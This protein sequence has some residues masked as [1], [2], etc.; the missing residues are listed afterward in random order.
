MTWPSS[1]R[2]LHTKCLFVL[3]LLTTGCARP[4]YYGWEASSNGAT[5]GGDIA[6]LYFD[7]NG[8]LYPAA[9]AF[10]AVD[11]KRL[12]K[13]GADLQDYYQLP[14]ARK[15]Q[16]A[17]RLEYER[18]QAHYGVPLTPSNPADTSVNYPAWRRLQEAMLTQFLAR[19]NQHLR[20]SRPEALVVL[21]HGFNNEVGATRWYPALQR[22]I[23]T[24]QFK[25]RRVQFLEV[26]WDGRTA[27][28]AGLLR[29]WKQAQAT[30]YP[31]GLGLRRVLASVD[32]A[33][34][35]Y[36]FGHSTGA[37][38]LS[39]A[40]WNSTS[41]LGNATGPRL[42]NQTYRA[43]VKQPEYATPHAAQVRVAFVAPAMPSL[44]FMDF[45]NRTDATGKLFTQTTPDG[46]QRF[47]VGQN[48]HDFATGKGPLSATAFGS[49]TLGV[50]KAE[51]CGD[52][53]TPPGIGVVPLLRQAGSHADT[54]LFNFTPGMAAA[55]KRSG[56]GILEFMTDPVT[57]DHLLDA[58]L[59]SKPVAGADSCP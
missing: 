14:A 44:H 33:T 43:L 1:N 24:N 48:R 35:L 2:L 19:F 28:G 37:P 41:V 13:A 18:L 20:T 49:T 23:R 22:E 59:T 26:Y 46:Y 36:L 51:Y 58:W 10:L 5:T 9:D 27:S 12:A 34:P 53:A 50:R 40:L 4:V 7:R 32:P 21:V 57:F 56:H 29:I 30:M 47:V 42:R 3:W 17:Q 11:N 38:L 8:N 39:V 52:G 16:A 6:R 25:G 45:A 55:G 15:E 54:Y 31:V